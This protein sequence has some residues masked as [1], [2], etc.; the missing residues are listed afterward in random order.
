MPAIKHFQSYASDR[1][2]IGTGKKREV[3]KT[4]AASKFTAY[5]GQRS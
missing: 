1:T 3:L 5:M 4:F 2:V